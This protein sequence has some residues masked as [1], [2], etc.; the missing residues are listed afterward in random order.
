MRFIA[1]WLWA[2]WLSSLNLYCFIH[3][4]KIMFILYVKIKQLTE[5]MLLIFSMTFWSIHD[6]HHCLLS[7]SPNFLLKLLPSLDQSAPPFIKLFYHLPGVAITWV[8][9][10]LSGA[11]HCL[12][13]C[14]CPWLHDHTAKTELSICLEFPVFFS[15]IFIWLSGNIWTTTINCTLYFLSHWLT[16]P[17]NLFF[18]ILTK[19]IL[20][21]QFPLSSV[22]N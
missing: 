13:A 12:W 1:V 4:L 14:T 22:S 6:S 5:W 8:P 16:F 11:S 19:E 15:N 9:H 2:S 7:P 20:N 10:V 3:R 21:F 17:S 18:F